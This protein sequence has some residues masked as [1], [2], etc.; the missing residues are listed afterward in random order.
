MVEHRF[1]RRLVLDRAVGLGFL[2]IYLNDAKVSQ[3]LLKLSAALEKSVEFSGVQQ[4]CEFG[5]NNL[6]SCNYKSETVQEK[7][8]DM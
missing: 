4:A 8:T 1:E 2:F 5:R 6:N 7:L 3:K